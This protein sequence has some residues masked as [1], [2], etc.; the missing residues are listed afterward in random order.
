MTRK[1][2]IEKTKQKEETEVSKEAKEMLKL[3]P[4]DQ[5]VDLKHVILEM[6]KEDQPAES[7]L[8]PALRYLSELFLSLFLGLS[9][10]HIQKIQINEAQL[11]CRGHSFRYIVW[12]CPS[13]WAV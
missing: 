11:N 2:I 9:R 7:I 10:G 12:P 6:L 3:I 8:D 4:D 5:V 13:R 1:V